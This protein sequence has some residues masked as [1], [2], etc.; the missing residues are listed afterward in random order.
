MLVCRR[1]A[2]R[3]MTLSRSV[4][5]SYDQAIAKDNPR[6]RPREPNEDE[7]G[8]DRDPDH[9]EK[10]LDRNDDMA[11]DRRRIVMA[12]ADG[13]KCLDTKEKGLGER[14]RHHVGDTVPTQRVESGE[15]EVDND[16]AADEKESKTRPAQG[17]DPVITVAPSAQRGI[18]LEKLRSPGAS[19][20][21]ST[22]FVFWFQP[23]HRVRSTRR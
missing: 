6:R 17:Q 3:Y 9:A 15:E 20:D 2:T 18:D 8:D 10:D 21:W 12:V 7:T 11:V 16:V 14:T 23:S 22:G 19:R 4:E 1:L 13:S 5:G